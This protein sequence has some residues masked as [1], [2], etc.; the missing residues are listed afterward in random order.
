VSASGSCSLRRWNSLVNPDFLLLSK[1]QIKLRP[2]KSISITIYSSTH[3]SST[4]PKNISRDPFPRCSLRLLLPEN[5]R[6]GDFQRI[7]PE[8]IPH[9][10]SQ[11]TTAIECDLQQ[12]LQDLWLARGI[13]R[14]KGF[15]TSSRCNRTRHPIFREDLIRP[16]IDLFSK[17]M[18]SHL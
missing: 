11:R 5:F 6:Q 17:A 10:G 4:V 13:R 1:Y 2:Q 7:P 8:D 16:T 14:R 12:R 18:H 9:G 3:F 15:M